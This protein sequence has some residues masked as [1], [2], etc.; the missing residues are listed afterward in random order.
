VG[1]L[2]LASTM[3]VNI[4]ER[5]REFGVMR[6]LG[7]KSNN[8]LSIV[9]TEGVTVGLLSFPLAFLLSLPLSLIVGIIAGQV[10]LQA[11]L[12]FALSPLGLLAWLLLVILLAALSSA[13]PALS[14]SR[15]TVRETLAYQ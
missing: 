2:G 3:S 12:V 6:T 15:L 11:P 8:V 4:L 5:T 7:A 1:G 9:I 10:G 13:L 14:A